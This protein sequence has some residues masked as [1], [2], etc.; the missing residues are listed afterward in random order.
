MSSFIDINRWVPVHT[1]LG[2]ECCI[3]YY[4]SRDGQVKSTKG[5][6]EK[7]LKQ[8]STKG[9]YLKV[10]L[11][12]R[13]G[14]KKPLQPYVHTLVALAFIGAPPTPQGRRIGCSV[15]DHKD[16]N[17]QNNH[18]DNLHWISVKENIC[19]FD[20]AKF[21]PVE[22]TEAERIAQEKRDKYNSKMRTRKYRERINSTPAAIEAKRLKDLAKEQHRAKRK[23]EIKEYKRKRHESIKNDPERLRAQREYQREY[24]RRKRAAEKKAKIEESNI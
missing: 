19:K 11:Q 24:M 5:G 20:Y 14:Q 16:E 23:E 17:K 1:L 6:K 12:Q 7:I 8:V 4:V 22:K 9:G 3:E 10:T 15:V 21:T 2:F 13:L 18:V